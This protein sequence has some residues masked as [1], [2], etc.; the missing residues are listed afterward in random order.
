MRGEISILDKYTERLHYYK[1]QKDNSSKLICLLN[2]S[3]WMINSIQLN[4]SIAARPF[5]LATTCLEQ[6]NV[7]HDTFQR[8]TPWIF[9]WCCVGF[10]NDQNYNS[11]FYIHIWYGGT[12]NRK[13]RAYIC[14][15]YGLHLLTILQ[16][17]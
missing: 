5:V 16:S 12:D 14:T 13:F 4:G 11:H 10:S 2:N 15:I 9:G 6:S 7:D 1:W 3:F 17:F 8:A